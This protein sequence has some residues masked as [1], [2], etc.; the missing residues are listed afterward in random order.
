M[1]KSIYH[2][3]ILVLVITLLSCN[4]SE[5]FKYKGDYLNSDLNSFEYLNETYLHVLGPD[6]KLSLSIWNHDDMAVGSAYSIYNTNESFGK[7]ILI[8][9][10]SCAAL[11]FIG[12]TKLGGLLIHEAEHLITTMLS[13]NIKDPIVE[14]KVLNKEITVLGEVKHPGNFKLEKETNS[15]VEAIGMAEGFNFYANTKRIIVVRDGQGCKIDLTKL[16]TVQ[17][18]NILLKSKDIVY[19]PSK[20]IKAV[21][22]NSPIII[23][24]ATALTSVGIIVSLTQ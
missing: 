7:W 21:Q 12:L 23:P 8:D 19:V 4:S 18:N 2:T 15:L 11:P 10:D 22:L 24:F 16:N 1:N 20:G 17:Q 6:D 5:L 14:L 13:E 9:Q 3:I